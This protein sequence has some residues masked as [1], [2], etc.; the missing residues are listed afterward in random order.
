MNGYGFSE[1]VS[2]LKSTIKNQK[3]NNAVI[4]FSKSRRSKKYSGEILK[5]ILLPLA[6]DQEIPKERR[7]EYQTEA[8]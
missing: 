2:A 5:V 7:R 1:G 3:N 8:C 4:L 6:G